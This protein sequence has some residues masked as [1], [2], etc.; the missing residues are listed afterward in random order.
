MTYNKSAIQVFE[1]PNGPHVYMNGFRVHHWMPGVIL[2]GLG[3]LG[4][5]LDD[6]KETRDKYVSS[7]VLGGLLILHDLPDVISFLKG[8]F[9]Q[10]F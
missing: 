6:R 2:A 5:V 7:T 1:T 3:L 8:T 10:T 4:L 9:N